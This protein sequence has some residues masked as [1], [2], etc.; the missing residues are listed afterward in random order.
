MGG[1]EGPQKGRFR[2]GVMKV[3]GGLDV[4]PA[5]AFFSWKSEFIEAKRPCVPLA[6]SCDDQL[7]SFV[8]L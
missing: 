8:G 3:T 1:L 6:D 5:Q 7:C 2:A 4:G